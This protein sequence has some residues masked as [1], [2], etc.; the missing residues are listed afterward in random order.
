MNASLDALQAMLD[1][2]TVKPE[3]FLPTGDLDPRLHGYQR[4]GVNHMHCNPKAG[5]FMEPG[6]GKTA[7]TL[8]TLHSDHFPVLVVAPKRVAT[9]VWPT[10]REIWRPDLSIAVAAG[11]PKKRKAALES[12]AQIVVI[13]RDN[14]KDVTPGQ[15]RTVVL[16]ELS[17]FKNGRLRGGS[18]RWKFA[19]RLCSRA[20][21]VYG[22][23]GTPTPNGLMDLWAQIYLLD[24]GERLGKTITAYRNRFFDAGRSIFQ[25]GRRVVIEWNPKPGAQERIEA[26]ISD[27]CLS[28]KAEDYL[29][30]EPV[31][32][33]EVRVPLSPKVRKVYDQMVGDLVVKTDENAYTAK[34]PAIK[35]GRLSQITAGFL[36]PDVEDAEI[37]EGEILHLHNEKTAAVVEIV[38][39][40]GSPVLV[41]YRYKEELARL[42][43]ALPQARRIDEPSVMD[44]WNR[45]EVEVLLAHPASAGHGLNLQH[46]GHTI[47]WMTMPNFDAEQWDQANARL[48][49]QGQK[50]PVTIHR[51][52]C[53]GT[54]DEQIFLAIT[55]K[56]SVQD[57]IMAALKME[58]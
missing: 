42:I 50:F 33:N 28:M 13:G 36:Y 2:A 51:L 44:E 40:T 1:A 55:G 9:E 31:I 56:I 24:G 27:I 11:D 7:T 58:D 26:L 32:H 57:A 18:Q 43:E 20:T 3:P 6:L 46:G 5:L 53:P 37:G 35:S 38:E 47:V 17:S 41:F 16:D 8:Q 12:G 29:E 49:R 15:F 34:N 22:L 4:R 30:L 52:V 45:G 19:N 39:G 21:Y 23:T 14:I 10:E 48:A 25:G 54:V